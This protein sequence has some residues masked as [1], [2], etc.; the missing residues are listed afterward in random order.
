M[1]NHM[2]VRR[3][4][5]SC[6]G[7]VLDGDWLE[8]YRTLWNGYSSRVERRVIYL[9]LIYDCTSV[10]TTAHQSAPEIR[11]FLEQAASASES[12]L[13][14]LYY[15]IVSQRLILCVYIPACSVLS[16]TNLS[17]WFPTQVRSSI[18]FLSSQ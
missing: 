11:L 2:T 9:V 3:S 6:I 18:P 4:Y 15:S 14:T 17:S 7:H 13:L 16:G 8:Y 12:Y 5:H 10:S 1:C